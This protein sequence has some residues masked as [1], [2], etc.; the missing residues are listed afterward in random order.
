MPERNIKHYIEASRFF[1]DPDPLNSKVGFSVKDFN[2]KRRS[3]WVINLEFSCKKMIKR[4]W[5]EILL[6][7]DEKFHHQF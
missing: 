1:Y 3:P 7:I 4:L 5:D 2:E 6:K